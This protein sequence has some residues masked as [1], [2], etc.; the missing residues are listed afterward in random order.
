MNE[1]NVENLLMP[2]HSVLNPRLREMLNEFLKLREALL[3]SKYWEQLNK[4]NFQQIS[5]SS[6]EN[7][8]HTVARNYLPFRPFECS[9]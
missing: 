4:K 6:Y 2:G 9:E 3:P 8:K 5:D 7:F 1:M